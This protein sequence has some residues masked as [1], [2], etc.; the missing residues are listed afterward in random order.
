MQFVPLCCSQ[1][2]QSVLIPYGKELRYTWSIATVKLY[3]A[4]VQHVN[5]CLKWS[6][7]GVLQSADRAAATYSSRQCFAAAAHPATAAA[8]NAI[9]AVATSLIC[10]CE[11]FCDSPYAL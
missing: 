2:Y 5:S 4:L 7:S 1:S 9:A 8:A 11:A 6:R 3:R 10:Y